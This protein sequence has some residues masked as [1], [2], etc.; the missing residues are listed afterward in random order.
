M[1]IFL[2]LLAIKFYSL[3]IFR[4]VVF[5]PSKFVDFHVCLHTV[6][7]IFRKTTA[8]TYFD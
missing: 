2:R 3:E 6:P 8:K 5:Q 4:C 1:L 7:Q